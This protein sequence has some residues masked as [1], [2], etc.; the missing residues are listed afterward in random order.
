MG[1]NFSLSSLAASFIFGTFGIYLFRHG[2]KRAH[3]PVLAIGI[4]LM[5]YP[6]FIENLFLLWAI[7]V[8]LLAL[9]YRL[10]NPKL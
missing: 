2:K 10:L 6:Y 4:A 1:L 7:G 5:I 8:G 9:A 3:G